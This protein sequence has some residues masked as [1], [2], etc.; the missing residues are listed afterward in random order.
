VK[1]H[2]RGESGAAGRFFRGFLIGFGLLPSVIGLLV[3]YHVFIATKT[4]DDGTELTNRMA[5]ATY[6]WIAI[7]QPEDGVSLYPWLKQDI[8]EFMEGE[9]SSDSPGEEKQGG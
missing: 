6:F 7:T 2:R 9:K 8:K 3:I 4:L 5:R 1:Y